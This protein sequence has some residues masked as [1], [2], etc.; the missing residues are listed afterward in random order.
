V[1][2]A[3]LSKTRVDASLAPRHKQL[4]RRGR[5]LPTVG[6]LDDIAGGVFKQDLVAA[7]VGDDVVA[8]AHSGITE[9]SYFGG[10]VGDDEVDAVPAAGA[11][12]VPPDTGRPAELAGPPSS[13]RGLPRVT[14]A[15]AGRRW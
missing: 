5:Q 14:S 15:K 9:P 8:E 3:S 6:K 2:R 10:G 7:G 13:S 11:G 4:P 1:L 12:L